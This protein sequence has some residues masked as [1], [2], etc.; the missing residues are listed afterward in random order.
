[1]AHIVLIDWNMT[2]RCLYE[3]TLSDVGHV[4]SLANSIEELPRAD[5]VLINAYLGGTKVAELISQLAKGL[6]EMPIILL[7]TS[8]MGRQ[9]ETIWPKGP[10]KA[11]DALSGPEELFRHI[12]E[13]LLSTPGKQYK[14]A[15]KPKKLKQ[16]TMEEEAECSTT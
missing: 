5:L 16:Q 6:V 1:V 8:L 10:V 15:A 11:L 13:I 9:I 4:I 12:N 7:C 2:T 14:D 3:R